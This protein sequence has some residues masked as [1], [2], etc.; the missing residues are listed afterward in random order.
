[1]AATNWGGN[2]RYRARRISAPASVEELQELVSR[3]RRLR[4]V[5]SRHSFT[6]IGDSAEL[7]TLDRIA[8]DIVIDRDAMTVSFGAAV[9]Y[10][11]L[12]AELERHGLALSNL[13]SLPH[14]AVGGAISTSTHGSGDGNG[15]LA[16]AV[17]ALEIVT[18]DGELLRTSR[19]MPDFDGLVVGLGA[20]GALTRIT[21]DAEPTYQVR[22]RVFDRLTWEAL[23]EHFDAIMSSG[24]SVSVFTRWGATTEHVWVKRRQPERPDLAPRE[25]FGA[26]AA[27]AERHP[28]PGL[29]PVNATPQLGVPGPWYERLPHFRMG[30]T[31]S[32][33][34]EIQSE[35]LLPRRNAVPAID[36]VRRLSRTIQPLTQI[37]E[38]RTV[39]ADGLWMSPQYGRD[40]VGI[41]FT[42][43][44]RQAA[45]EQAL[46]E[47]EQALAPF[48]ARPHWGKLFLGG[49]EGVGWR[50]ERLGDFGDLLG[51]LD[52]GGVFRNEWLESRV[53]GR[54]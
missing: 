33:G 45:V 31:P 4:V 23:F 53:F 14:V 19:G 15:S 29:D 26:V 32:S 10:G 12:A 35:Y 47:V 20:V 39:A 3:S 36:A 9:R 38:I 28:I 27:T 30:F 49:P 42:W 46:A 24:Y 17:T 34:A 16:T 41:H 18:A 11:E 50:Y 48:D 5:G 40:T 7:V 51:R 43:L 52:P 44:P 2:Y 37:S 22:Q 25:L 1:M 8:P 13:G 6:A 21:L 54:G